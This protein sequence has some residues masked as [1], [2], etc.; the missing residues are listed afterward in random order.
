MEYVFLGLGSNLGDRSGF[1]AQARQALQELPLG[2]FRESPIYESEP[3][4]GMRQPPYLN[5]VVSGRTELEASALLEACLQIE[6]VLGRTRTERWGS[7]TIDIDILAYGRSVIHQPHL[8]VPHPEM[9]RRSFVLLPMSLLSPEWTHPRSGRSIEQL[10]DAWQQQF[11][12]PR[13]REWPVSSSVP[14]PNT[15]ASGRN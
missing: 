14:E 6:N 4:A 10:W 7:R 8:Q 15:S 12:D 9:E 3:L 13:P 2:D 5:Q 11:S 1:L